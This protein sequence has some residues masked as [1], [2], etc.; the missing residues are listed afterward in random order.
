MIMSS[1][2]DNLLSSIIFLEGSQPLQNEK[3]DGGWEPNPCVQWSP[4]IRK[5]I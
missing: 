2:K 5:E 1:G 3:K 4:H